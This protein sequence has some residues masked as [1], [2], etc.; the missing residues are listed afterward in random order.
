MLQDKTG[1]I[2]GKIWST[3]NLKPVRRRL[4]RATPQQPSAG[5]QS[6][7]NTTKVRINSLLQ[8]SKEL[9]EYPEEILENV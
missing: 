5:P 4:R 2:R 3:A 1:I 8:W 7:P 9:E 6:I